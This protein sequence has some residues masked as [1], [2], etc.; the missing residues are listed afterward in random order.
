MNMFWHPSLIFLG[1]ISLI[2]IPFT[3]VFSG[4]K[5]L[6]KPF[7]NFTFCIAALCFGLSLLNVIGQDDKGLLITFFGT[8]ILFV[9]LLYLED[10]NLMDERLTTIGVI[11]RVVVGAFY[12]FVLDSI[13]YLL[14]RL[15]R[16]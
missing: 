13:Q 2:G 8:D 7:N 9:K 16:D 5:F 11:A 1:I 10:I 14:L 15:N 4:I 3:L 12:G 6:P